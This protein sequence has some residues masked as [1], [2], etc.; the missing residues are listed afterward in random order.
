MTPLKLPPKISDAYQNRGRGSLLFLFFSSL[1]SFIHFFSSFLSQRS[2]NRSASF[3]LTVALRSPSPPLSALLRDRYILHFS[4]VP[5]FLPHSTHTYT[6]TH[7][8]TCSSFSL[9]LLLLIQSRLFARRLSFPPIMHPVV[10]VHR[11]IVFLASLLAVSLFLSLFPCLP[12]SPPPLIL[13]IRTLWFLSVSLLP[14]AEW[15]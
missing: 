11:H 15:K 12:S 3:F 1:L 2:Y 8:N 5:S 13:L 6:H 7:T 9:S 10:D 14:A 4:L